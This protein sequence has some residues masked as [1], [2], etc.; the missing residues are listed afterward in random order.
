MRPRSFHSSFL[1]MKVESSTETLVKFCQTTRRHIPEH[2]THG[3]HR[4]ENLI[5]LYS[6]L[7]NS[8]EKMLSSGVGRTGKH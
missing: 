7:F 4:L 5:C 3:S 6:T 2:S 1:K 8:P